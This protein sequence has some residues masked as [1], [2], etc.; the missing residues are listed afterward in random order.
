M[1]S[2]SAPI[3]PQPAA[4]D[5]QVF[6]LCFPQYSMRHTQDCER[7]VGFSFCLHVEAASSI[8]LQIVLCSYR[9]FLRTML[10]HFYGNRKIS[11][12]VN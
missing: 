2:P 4:G 8:S 9:C 10:V 7:Q 6:D 11:F 5:A 3:L 12:T 1:L